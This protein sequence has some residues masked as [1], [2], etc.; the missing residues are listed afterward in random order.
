MVWT[1]ESHCLGL[2][3]APPLTSCVTLSSSDSPTSASRIAG[4]TGMCHH[5]WLILYFLVETGFLHV[6][7]AGLEL[8][9]SGDLPA[10]A[11]QSAGITGISHYTRPI[12]ILTY[13]YLYLFLFFFFFFNF[14]LDY[15][16]W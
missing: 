15:R 13:I 7:Q 12:F 5:T 6:G 1:L 2:S 3:P 9:T 10:S 14:L 8:P 4:I 16:F 11:S